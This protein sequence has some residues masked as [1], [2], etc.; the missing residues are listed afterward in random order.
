MHLLAKSLLAAGVLILSSQATAQITFYER[1]GF[2]GRAFSAQRAVPDFSRGGI[3]DFAS[4]VVVERGHWEVCEDSRYRGR[5]MV[6]RQGSY[7]SL[8]GMGLNNRISSMRPVNSRANYANA[9]PAPLPQPTYAYRRRSN[10]RVYEAPVT[11]V[12]AV[13]GQASQRCWIEREQLGDRGRDSRNVGGAIAGAIIGGILGHQVG[14]G[15]GRDAATV[16][17]ALA[18]AAIGSQA[19]SG[20]DNRYERGYERDIRRCERAPRG[21]PQY[22]DVS[23]EYRGVEHW[24]RMSDPPGRTIAVNRRGEPRQ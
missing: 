19:G 9:A 22:W 3:N 12:R 2:R 11:S 1:E 17:G 5:C 13:M 15:R 16:G 7:D 21:T 6:L 20:S 18:G 8:R 24:I 10:E 23:Y 14:D 4:S